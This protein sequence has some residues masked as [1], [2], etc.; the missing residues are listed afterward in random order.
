MT[1]PNTRINSQ[2]HRCPQLRR[3]CNCSITHNH[4]NSLDMLLQVNL[5]EITLRSPTHTPLPRV[6][7][8]LNS[9]T[10][11]RLQL[12]PLRQLRRYFSRNPFLLRLQPPNLS[13][14]RQQHPLDLPSWIPLKCAIVLI[15]RSLRLHTKCTL[16]LPNKGH[17]NTTTKSTWH[18][19]LKRIARG[20]GVSRIALL[21]MCPL[22]DQIA[23]PLQ[24]QAAYLH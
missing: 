19:A 10:S 15:C 1:G 21:Q 13:T 16:E 7:F 6:T 23:G 9:R 12:S 14:V 5:L 4:H 2:Q 18:Q 17:S 3:R 22:W 8:Q 24:A 11:R 20:D